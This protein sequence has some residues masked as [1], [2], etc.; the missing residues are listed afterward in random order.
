MVEVILKKEVRKLG[1][2]GDVVSVAPG[3]ARNFLFP[4][5]FAM[6]ATAANKKQLEEMQTAAAKEADQLTADATQVAE[7]MQ[8]VVLR[9]EE[10]ASETG[11]LFGSVATRDIAAQLAEQ[12][13]DIDRHQIILEKPF[14]EPGDYDVR[15]H[16]YRDVKVV[17]KVEV[18]AEGQPDLVEPEPE[19]EIEAYEAVSEETDEEAVDDEAA[20]VEAADVADELEDE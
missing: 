8:D 7:S 13:H 20:D 6:P 4:Q 15:V 10:R 11:L 12:G 3:Y 1:D 16:L 14:K 18:R 17:V 5:K 2:R 9:F 19:P